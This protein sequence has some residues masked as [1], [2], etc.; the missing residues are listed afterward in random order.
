MSERRSAPVAVVTGGARR[1]GRHLCLALAA[2]GYDLVIL[3][4]ESE[5]DARSL[6]QEI[7]AAG[8]R[9]RTRAV[10]VGVE[11]AGGRGLRRDRAR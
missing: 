5:A 3:Y 2:R 9:A 7:P 8:R 4:R 11:R 6:E 1:L 10:D